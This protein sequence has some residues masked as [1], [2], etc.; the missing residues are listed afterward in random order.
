VAERSTP[1]ATVSRV[2]PAA[3]HGPGTFIDVRL[4]AERTSSVLVNSSTAFPFDV[5]D[6]EKDA[7]AG[8]APV[9]PFAQFDVP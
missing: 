7:M 2:T 3:T 4:S 9:P 6:T 1:P 5:H 8:V